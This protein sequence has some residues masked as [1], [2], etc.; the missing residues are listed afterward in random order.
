MSETTHGL[1]PFG[2]V[3]HILAE[4]SKGISVCGKAV[5]IGIGPDAFTN[6]GVCTRC[7]RGTSKRDPGGEAVRAA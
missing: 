6:L 5:V 7:A 4:G 2:R 1:T 3:R